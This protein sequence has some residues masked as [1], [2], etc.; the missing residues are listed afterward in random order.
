MLCISNM[1][2]ILVRLNKSLGRAIVVTL[3]SVFASE[4][5][6]DVLVKVFKDSYLLNS[7]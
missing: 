4:C 7:P 3:E 1:Y 2:T 6:S 5:I